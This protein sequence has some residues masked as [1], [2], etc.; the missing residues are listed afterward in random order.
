MEMV[1]KKLLFE[2]LQLLIYTIDRNYFKKKKMFTFM[3]MK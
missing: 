2:D 3:S 1:A